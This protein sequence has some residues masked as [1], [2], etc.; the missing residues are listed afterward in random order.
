M[1]T[2]VSLNVDLVKAAED[3]VSAAAAAVES[4]HRSVVVEVDNQL[5]VRLSFDSS[6]HDHGGFGTI[7][8]KG[9]IE[10]MSSDVFN[11]QSS[12]KLTSA[13]APA[14]SASTARQVPAPPLRAGPH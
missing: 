7:L 9:I 8:P 6:D 5:P 3:I 14:C 2:D 1:A 12:G 11:S 4:S 13:R 10:S